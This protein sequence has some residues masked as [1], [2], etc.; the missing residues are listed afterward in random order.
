MYVDD[1]GKPDKR[2]RNNKFFG[3][4]AVIINECN[5]K[6]I[7]FKIARLKRKLSISE[8]HTRNIYCREKEFQHLNKNPEKSHNILEQIF[9]MIANFDITLISFHL[10]LIDSHNSTVV[11][12]FGCSYFKLNNSL[13]IF[14]NC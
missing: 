13:L 11:L 7:N 8:I 5:W 4:S 12:H 9:N 3:L 10:M 1:S 6:Q 2:L 14:I